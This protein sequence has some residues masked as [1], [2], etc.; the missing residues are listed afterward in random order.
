MPIAE[1]RFKK[2]KAGSRWINSDIKVLAV[3]KTYKNFQ[4]SLT[5]NREEAY[6]L[7]RELQDMNLEEIDSGEE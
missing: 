1:I 6:Q 4:K 2:I 5:F 7:L 3:T